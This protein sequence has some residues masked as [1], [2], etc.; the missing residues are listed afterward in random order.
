MPNSFGMSAGDGWSASVAGQ[1]NR[2]F[3]YVQLQLGAV[4]YPGEAIPSGSLAQ[5]RHSVHADGSRLSGPLVVADERQRDA[6][7]YAGEDDA[8]RHAVEL[9]AP[10]P[11][12]LRMKLFIARMDYV[13]DIAYQGGTTAG[14]PDSS[15]V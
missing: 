6:H 4:A 2:L 3:D 1:L 13:D 8:R 10:D 7:R 11:F 12:Q 5:H 9:R 14:H 15:R